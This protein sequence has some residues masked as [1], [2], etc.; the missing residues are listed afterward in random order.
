[1]KRPPLLLLDEPTSNLDE[2]GKAIIE[3]VIKSHDGIVI[4]ATNEENELKYGNQ[5]IALGR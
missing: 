3:D 1:M 5:K 4:I 2:Q